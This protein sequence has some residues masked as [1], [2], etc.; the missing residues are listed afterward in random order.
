[1]AAATPAGIFSFDIMDAPVV[2]GGAVPDSSDT[3]RQ[4]E[5]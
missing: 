5:H 2:D 3:T 4:L 1:M